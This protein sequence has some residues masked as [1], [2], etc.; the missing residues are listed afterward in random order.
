M[1]ANDS[2]DYCDLFKAIWNLSFSRP[3][4]TTGNRIGAKSNDDGALA[5]A[6]TAS[7]MQESTP[8]MFS[9][10]GRTQTASRLSHAFLPGRRSRFLAHCWKGN[11]Q[12]FF[13]SSVQIVEMYRL[14]RLHILILLLVLY[15]GDVIDVVRLCV[16]RQQWR[17]ICFFGNAMA[18]GN[19][20]L[21]TSTVGEYQQWDWSDMHA[22][23]PEKLDSSTPLDLQM[24]Q[25]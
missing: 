21:N 25:T 3:W 1:K 23:L 24:S 7:R 22:C 17:F 8:A 11:R 6:E 12:L 13:A 19:H 10:A 18:A 16:C 14:S 4:S 2:V 20:N 5:T 15:S 9:S